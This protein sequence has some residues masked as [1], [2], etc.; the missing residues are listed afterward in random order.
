M[1]DNWEWV[2]ASDRGRDDQL[3]DQISTL[4]ELDSQSRHATA[5]LSSQLSELQG[6]LD[7][8]LSALSA[9]FD[10]YVELGDIRAEL[11]RYPDTGAIRN[12]AVM[13]LVTLN[14]GATP[15]AIDP[16]GLDYWLAYA[17]NAVAALVAGTPDR[18]AEQR[19]VELYPD[20]EWFLVAAAGAFGHGAAVGDRVPALLTCDGVLSARQLL[21]W[22]AV[23]EG[24]YG[25][26]LPA[27]GVLWRPMVSTDALS[28]R[29]WLVAV[30][31]SSAPADGLRWISELAAAADLATG[32]AAE[33]GPVV[34][35][36]PDVAELLR[37]VA[38]ELVGRGRGEE[39]EILER[40]RVLRARIENPGATD[41]AATPVADGP[42]IT[43]AV[44]SALESPATVHHQEVIRWVAPELL[45]A[46]QALV[47]EAQE[48]R[49]GTV[50]V[51]TEGGHFDVSDQGLAPSELARAEQSITAAYR[52]PA[53]RIAVPVGLTG[54]VTVLALVLAVT[55]HGRG[56]LLL[57]LVACVGG[58]AVGLAVHSRTGMARRAADGI[59]DL[60]REVAEAQESAALRRRRSQ[61]AALE[62]VG[63]FEDVRTRLSDP[64]APALGADQ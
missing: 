52:Y 17:V 19:A 39:S 61:Q 28:W 16:R 7:S 26:V 18:A 59:A 6:S 47:A 9:A 15:A 21:L 60:H 44:R 20:A 24:R 45:A 49:P 62:A 41:R 46:A 48:A 22:R 31:P 43:E 4:Q 54:L 35:P 27:V 10:A 64:V 25:P 36:T 2:F 51:L 13:A 40:A 63:L 3:R 32:S 14:R 42:S 29:N 30:S 1:P 23:L 58:V 56:A 34:P 57:L 53:R 50:P 8:R 5:R 11:E 55:G 33:S 38:L 37:G 12:E